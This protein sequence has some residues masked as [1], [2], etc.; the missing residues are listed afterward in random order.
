MGTGMDD[1]EGAVAVSDA[2]KK[3]AVEPEPKGIDHT[4][5]ILE[6]ILSVKEDIQETLDAKILIGSEVEKNLTPPAEADAG[7]G[8]TVFEALDGGA[9]GRGD[10]GGHDVGKRMFENWGVTLRRL[11]P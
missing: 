9:E 11:N 3:S 8:A 7:D 1:S 6:M 5:P 2:E 10:A 4:I